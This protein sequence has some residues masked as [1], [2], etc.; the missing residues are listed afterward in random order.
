MKK[1]VF[2]YAIISALFMQFLFG[3]YT[4]KIEKGSVFFEVSGTDYKEKPGNPPSLKYLAGAGIYC[5]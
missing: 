1:I 2:F 4:L 3:Q 5:C